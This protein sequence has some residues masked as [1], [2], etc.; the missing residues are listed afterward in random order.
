MKRVIVR[1]GLVLCL[2]VAGCV[3]KDAG[4]SGQE[5]EWFVGRTTRREV[6]AA[7]GNPDRIDGNVWKWKA[8]RSTGGKFKLGYMGVGMT[9]SNS[10]AATREYQLEFGEDGRLRSCQKVD[11][12]PEG[13]AW[14][15]WP[16]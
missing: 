14:S 3:V 6:V 9:L 16:F 5:R 4:I 1:A 15:V 10:R 12:V 2:L 13:A 7:W 11:S 8:W